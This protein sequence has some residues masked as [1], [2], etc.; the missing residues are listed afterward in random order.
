MPDWEAVALN[1]RQIY[2]IFDSDVM[3]K[4]Q[5]HAALARFKPFL[6]SRGAR[7]LLIYLPVDPS[8][9][10]TGVDDYLVAGHSMDDLQALAT[11]TLRSLAQEANEHDQPYR[12]TESGLLWHKPTQNGVV[13]VP[14]TNFTARIIGDVAEDDGA[15]VRRRFDIAATLRGRSHHFS[16]PASQ[17]A[18]MGWSVEQLG[19][20]A[21]V[22]PGFG[23][24][25]HA[26]TA[27]Q[28]LSGAIPE[29][30]VYTHT[31]WRKVDDGWVFLHAG[32]TIGSI[33][34]VLE[35]IVNLPSALARF[36]L[37]SPLTGD[38][39]CEAV[40]ASLA[41]L[42]VAPDQVTVPCLSA[43][44]RAVL[45][46][47]DFT[48]HLAGPTGAGKTELAALAQQHFGP[49][50]D[51][52]HLPASWLSTGNAL[53]GLA[54]LAK[55]VLLV[56]DDFAPTGTSNDVQRY[57]KEADRLF[58]GQGNQ[59]GRGRM[60]SD[61]SLRPAKPP[62]GLILSTGEDIP[63]GLSLR[64]RDLFLELGPN[65]LDWQRLS[66]CQQDAASGRYAL[67]MAGYLQWLAADYETIQSALPAETAA[68][69]ELATRDRSHRRT[70][71][72]IADLAVGLQYFL[73]FS[74]ECG[75]ITD[76]EEQALWERCWTALL[77]AGAAQATHHQDAEPTGRFL[78]LLRACLGSGRVH[79]ASIDGDIPENPQAWGWREASVGIGNS[80]Q[81]E[82]HAQGRRVGWVEDD[83]LYLEPDAAFAAVQEMGNQ[84]GEPLT[85][86]S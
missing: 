28:L 33:G 56:V 45:G 55:D 83:D 51:S 36:A 24:K 14:L 27:V 5:V 18:N 59:A 11:P 63:R 31:G 52:R 12:A 37:P 65:D 60:R 1:G 34:T 4:H 70:P 78:Q 17:F 71:G 53:E 86:L 8:G 15:E 19:A 26:R 43:I 42:D 54:F 7:V 79:L 30:R 57:H 77:V 2:V 74:V 67:I 25:D 35:I 20:G 44:Y 39:L 58:R 68:L 62:R 6:E 72:I 50:M 9:K 82:W 61:G 3:L 48:L 69:R 16:V 81:G 84:V 76:A 75:A 32:G 23:L 66:E 29:R 80:A 47:I 49:T 22:Y 13:D 41:L 46:N 73:R 10:K 85:I 38:A 21:I 64:A 40:R